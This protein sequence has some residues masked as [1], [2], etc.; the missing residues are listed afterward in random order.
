MQYSKYSTYIL[1]SE[2]DES[3]YIGYSS[4][5]IDRLRKHNNSR[6][7][8]TSTK[9]PWRLEYVESF[10][11]KTEVIKRENQLKSWKDSGMI[12]DLIN[13]VRN[14]LKGAG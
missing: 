6:K 5:P 11:T 10:K 3:Y 13:S 14:E 2:K 9:K 8:Y 4:N 7:G 12:K 1:Q